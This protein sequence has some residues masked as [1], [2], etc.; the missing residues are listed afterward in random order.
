MGLWDPQIQTDPEQ[1]PVVEDLILEEAQEDQNTAEINLGPVEPRKG[2][3]CL[4]SCS[5][6]NNLLLQ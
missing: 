5:F 1:N 6:I 4:S 3:S 2:P